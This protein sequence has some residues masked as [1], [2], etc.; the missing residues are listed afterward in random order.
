MIGR[1]FIIDDDADLGDE[2][3]G[4]LVGA[5]FDAHCAA[6]SSAIFAA[7]ETDIDVIVLDLSMP[8]D[9]FD[10]VDELALRAKSPHIIISSGQDQRIVRAAV[11]HA[12]QAGL[13]IGGVLAKPYFP[14]ELIRLLNAL[15]EAADGAI[16]PN[17]P[18]TTDDLSDVLAETHVV[19]QA[20]VGLG[21]ALAVEGYEALLR[22][23][24]GRS[25][26][27]LFE[28]DV[29][30]S[31]QRALTESVIREAGR[32]YRLLYVRSKAV[33]ISVNLTPALLCDPA[34]IA[35]LPGLAH[36]AS[37]PPEALVLELTEHASLIDFAVVA[38]AASRLAMRGFRLAIDDFGRG[39]TSLERIM[40]L[41]VAELKI[42]KE[43]FW[44]CASGELPAAILRETI[45]YCRS[46]AI[47]A[48]VE[49]IETQAHVEFARD[50]G[51]DAG[52]GYLWGKPRNPED[53][54]GA[55]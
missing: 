4:A 27:R 40:G 9:G 5:G 41:P 3:C 6:T 20:K 2:L 39:S 25:P 49:G 23:R 45:S 54:L 21:P 13:A 50:L 29:P 30:L 19:F 55:A 16:L 53:L 48:T 12:E 35:A 36:E 28:P 17:V 47:K 14:S 51:A 44:S 32:F 46:H 11:R 10:L 18:A 26:E 43:I 42:D 33:D 7:L 8:L 37:L 31:V 22:W 1:V 38:S 52:Q 15:G 24:P 34:F